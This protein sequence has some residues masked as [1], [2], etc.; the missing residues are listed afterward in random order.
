M[1]GQYT[2]TSSTPVTVFDGR[3]VIYDR[4]IIQNN[5]A[6]AVRITLG[7]TTGGAA[8]A[9]TTSQG[10][11]IAAGDNF[12]LARGECRLPAKIDAIAESASTTIDVVTD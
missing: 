7:G 1:K 6:G 3:T 12:P 8:D 10:I 9:P 2:V 5:G 4:V 11:R